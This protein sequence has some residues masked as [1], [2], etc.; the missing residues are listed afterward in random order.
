MKNAGL[1]VTFQP[2]TKIAFSMHAFERRA[3]ANESFGAFVRFF[4]AGFASPS[5]TR[6]RLDLR[7]RE[8]DLSAYALATR[9]LTLGLRHQYVDT[10]VRQDFADIPA[11][12]SS[13]ARQS[14]AATSSRTTGTIVFNH[15]SGLFLRAETVWTRLRDRSGSVPLGEEDAVLGNIELGYRARARRWEVALGFLN[16]TDREFIENGLSPGLDLPRKAAVVVTFHLNL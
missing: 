7:E 14:F 6:V 11:A 9:A 1:A 15:P 8:L 13:L 16:F 5:Q 3:A 10:S 2:V 12:V 4:P